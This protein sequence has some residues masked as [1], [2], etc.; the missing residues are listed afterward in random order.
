MRKRGPALIVSVLA[1]TLL[2]IALCL[3]LGSAPASAAIL[4]ADIAAVEL[5]AGVELSPG[6]SRRADPGEI[7]SYTHHHQHWFL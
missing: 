3:F 7:V 5:D 4:D 6:E 2:L 1:G